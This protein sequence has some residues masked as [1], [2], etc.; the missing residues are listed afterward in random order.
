MTTRIDYAKIAPAVL[1]GMGALGAAVNHSGLPKPLLELV[2]LRA[3]FSNGCAYCVDM[4]TKDALAAGETTQRLFGVAV[5]HETPYFTPSERAA[6]AWTDALTH[7]S[8]GPPS[9]ELFEDLSEHFSPEEI[10]HLTLAIVAIN[11]WNR[12]ALGLGAEVGS[13]QVVGNV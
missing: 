7:I 2:K 8:D 6:L 4:H 11:G 12:I 1:R 9:D 3:S 5:W 13:Y 10:A